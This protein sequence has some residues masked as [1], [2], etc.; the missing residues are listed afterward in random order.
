[1]PIAEEQLIGAIRPTLFIG[2]GGTGKEVLLRLR[3]KFYERLGEPGLP[4]TAYMWIDT[5]TRDVMARGERVDEIYQ[6]VAFEEHEKIGLLKGSVGNDLGSIFLNRGQWEHLHEWVYPEVNR[7][8][9]EIADGAGGVRAVG[10]LTFFRHFNDEI[11]PKLSDILGVGGIGSQE[12]INR[13]LQ[14]FKDRKLGTPQFDTK[15]QVV[16]VSSLAGGT[17][18]GTVLDTVFFLRSLSQSERIPIERLVGILFMP[19]VFYA[20][21]QDEASN[22]SYGNAYAALKEIEFYTLRLSKDEDLSIDYQVRWNRDD[23]ERVQGPPFSVAYIEE[24][25]NEGG[26]SLQPDNRHE[27]FS[28]VAE[29]LLLDFMPGAFSTE[30]RSQYS[31]VVQYLSGVSGANVASGGVTLPQEFAR[32][33]ASFGMSKIEIPLDTLK[34]AAAALL[35]AEMLAYINRASSDPHIKTSVLDD[36]AQ[37]QVDVRGLE[38]RFQSAW[39]DSIKDALKEVFRGLTVKDMKEFGDLEGRLKRFE[40]L[41]LYS[42][43]GDATKWGAAID[44][45]RKT[46]KD[47]KHNVEESLSGWIDAILEKDSRGLTS[48]LADDGYLNYMLSN[49][50]DLYRPAGDGERAAYDKLADEA[51]EDAE[52]YLSRKQLLLRDLRQALTSI[53]V[54]GL[55]EKE[56]TVAEYLE[57]VHEAEEQY[58]LAVAARVLCEEAKKVAEAAAKYLLLRRP[59]LDKFAL[60]A[61][62]MQKSFE[63][64]FQEFINF[65]DQV[66]FV[67]FF[68]RERDWMEFYCLGADEHGQS[69]AVNPRAEYARFIGENFGGTAT[70]SNLIELHDRKTEKEV[71]KLLL[72]FTEGRFWTDFEAHP[73]QIDVLEHPKMRTS[74]NETIERLVRSA[75]PMIRRRADLA[76]NN[77]QVQKRAFLGVSRL[78]GGVYQDFIEEV[79]KKLIG[80]GYTVQ[81][82]SAHPTEKPWEVYLYL[83][84]Y[85]FPLAAL[86]IVDTDCYGAYF[87]FYR[88]LRQNQIREQRY[89]IPL[90][91]SQAWEGKFD[92]LVVYKDEIAKQVKEA[93]EALLFG[94]I[95]KVLNVNE[96]A[97]RID[98]GYKL[99]APFFRINTLGPKREAI[100][101][102][103]ENDQLRRTLLQAINQ[104][105]QEATAEQLQTYYWILQYLRFAQDYSKSSPEMTLLNERIQPIYD[106]LVTDCKIPAVDL[107][108][109][110]SEEKTKAATAKTRIGDKAEWI[111]SVPVLREL[112]LWTKSAG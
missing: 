21:P 17:G 9:A 105:E 58:G 55:R 28:M 79:K 74:W 44:I 43:G 52:E 81:E 77:L 42:Q 91:L 34:G 57:R 1:M 35:T 19:N 41:Q 67:R 51:A 36:M 66:L 53:G 76:G 61:A 73:R 94:A 32:R 10:R 65:G 16:I 38:D 4:C 80:R 7:Y 95:L 40:D 75:M 88:A 26:I 101:S 37:L 69:Q 48:L 46:T 30:K 6:A 2:L 100:E 8:G 78:E 59:I 84:S 50:Q 64:K 31:N 13:T 90:H 23:L 86:P 14:L 45:L 96:E 102:L 63:E 3:R 110:G 72:K 15:P 111:G 25:V 109:E 29:S 89:Q 68:D 83:V 47:V 62:A 60:G 12:K 93:R 97:Q 20:S 85:A 104:R 71:K 54:A 49:L 11:K 82:I 18:C 98:Y 24:M 92:E 107:S 56:W 5:D 27:I 22:R 106:R 70:L 87:D 103:R 33:Y 108:L 112:T 39:K 99:G